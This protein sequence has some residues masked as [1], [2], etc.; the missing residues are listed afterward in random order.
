MDK[1]RLGS[2]QSAG[3]KRYSRPTL[4]V[5]GD[6]RE[7]TNG[8]TVGTDTHKDSGAYPKNRTH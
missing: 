3:K 8:V 2:S 5:Y 7:I 4:Q 1:S 6:L